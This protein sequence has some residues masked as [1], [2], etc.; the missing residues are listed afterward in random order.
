MW[1]SPFGNNLYEKIYKNNSKYLIYDIEDN[2]LINSKS[3][4]NPINHYLRSS[5]KYLYLIKNANHTITSAPDLND[6]CLEISQNLNS[7]FISPGINLD[8]YNNK[9]I[10]NHSK[11]IVTIGWTGTFSSI[12]YLKTLEKVFL[13]LSKLVKF[14]LVVIGNFDYDLNGLD[15]EMIQWNKNTEIEDLSKI[16]IGVYPLMKDEKWVYG[17]SGLKAIQY[18]AMGIP[19][20]STNIGN[21]KNFVIHNQNGFLVND[22]REWEKILYDLVTNFNLRKKIGTEARKT[23]EDKFGNKIIRHKYL[24]IL[25]KS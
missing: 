22:D 9:K 24:N 11:D 20:V 5:K 17:K 4:V 7:T 23:V 16:D 1:V 18:M 2:L 19:S 25:K 6:L 12:K 10:I 13:N 8:R 14:K 15:I 3:D 21:V